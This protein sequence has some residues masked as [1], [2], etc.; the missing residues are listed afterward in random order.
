MEA[1]HGDVPQ[2]GK[3]RRTSY[4]LVVLKKEKPADE[5]QVHWKQSKV[6]Y[7]NLVNCAQQ[8]TNLLYLKRKRARIRR[9]RLF[10]QLEDISRYYLTSIILWTLLYVGVVKR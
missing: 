4:Q 9:F 2:F 3:L 8:V 5:E 10:Y 7:R 1:K 6:T